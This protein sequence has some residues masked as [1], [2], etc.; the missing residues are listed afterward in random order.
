MKNPKIARLASM[1]IIAL[2]LA[3]IVPCSAYAFGE[4]AGKVIIPTPLGGSGVGSWGIGHNETVVVALRV[5][6][7]AAKYI[8][9][10]KEIT[11]TPDQMYWVNVTAN[12]PANYNVSNGTNITG[13][14]Y[15]TLKGSPGQVQI[16]LQ[17]SKTVIIMVEAPQ[18]SPDIMMQIRSFMAGLGLASLMDSPELSIG[19]LAIAIIALIGVYYFAIKSRRKNN[20][21][22][23]RAVN[24]N[25]DFIASVS[26]D[27]DNS[28]GTN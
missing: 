14:M 24:G 1:A 23:N 4:V 10:P 18:K 6:G 11:I 12:V 22:D 5:E 15:A 28:V 27:I 13:I 21:K 7:A 26:A 9:L 8:S 2:A 19:G 25:S 20:E 17:L 3:A 16:N